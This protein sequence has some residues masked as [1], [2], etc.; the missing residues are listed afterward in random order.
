MKFSI[1][2]IFLTLTILVISSLF[3]TACNGKPTVDPAHITTQKMTATTTAT[4]SQNSLA[5][6][7]PDAV[8]YTYDSYD[9]VI[10]DCIKLHDEHTLRYAQVGTDAE[11][12]YVSLTD[13][14]IKALNSL[15][16]SV[17]DFSG[18]TEIGGTNFI[19]I[20]H[21]GE[22]DYFPYLFAAQPELNEYINLLF[23]Y[24]GMYPIDLNELD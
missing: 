24:C 8:Y 15:Y 23:E 19:Q 14:Q 17:T 3:I 6:S 12:Q 4:T 7:M 2:R 20:D 11:V 13:E 18:Q 10:T 16:A 9:G 22:T 5:L 21:D 1:R